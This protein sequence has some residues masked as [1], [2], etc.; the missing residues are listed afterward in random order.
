MAT[1]KDIPADQYIAALAA[2]FK[3]SGKIELPAWH[4]IVK[5]GVNR[6]LPPLDP[7]WF[8]IRAGVLVVSVPL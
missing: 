3:S 8:Y 4:D 5:T 7:D 2:H 1:V 6:E